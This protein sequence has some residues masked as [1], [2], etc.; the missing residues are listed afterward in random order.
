[1]PTK[2]GP[3]RVLSD[4]PP[5]D[6]LQTL[7]AFRIPRAVL[8]AKR[9]QLEGQAISIKDTAEGKRPPHGGLSPV[10]EKL[11]PAFEAAMYP[12]TMGP[13]QIMDRMGY[14]E[15]IVEKRMPTSA[16]F[17]AGVVLRTRSGSLPLCPESP[18]VDLRPG[19][20]SLEPPS[21]KRQRG[22]R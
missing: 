9:R 21:K 15:R 19:V 18:V 1:M 7:D 10:D 11:A 5:D 4:R 6:P 2:K 8:L 17:G 3:L 22:G 14:G 20:P 13:E 16:R 12:A